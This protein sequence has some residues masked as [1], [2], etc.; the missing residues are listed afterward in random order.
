MAEPWLSCKN[1]SII[2]SPPACRGKLENMI[3]KGSNAQRC[4]E[5]WD[6]ALFLLEDIFFCAKS[7]EVCE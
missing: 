1:K 5:E 6:V 2:C 3:L 4:W 7:Y